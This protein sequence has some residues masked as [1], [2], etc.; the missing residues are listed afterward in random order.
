MEH[1][2]VQLNFNEY[3]A[4]LLLYAANADFEIEKEELEIIERSLDKEDYERV[5]KAFDRANDAERLEVIMHYKKIYHNTLMDAE[6]VTSQLKEVF[7]A[8]EEYPS[9]EK[10]VFMYLKKLLNI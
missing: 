10:A 4:Y 8:D 1:E 5:R 9:I 6:A 7:M 2:I 3:I